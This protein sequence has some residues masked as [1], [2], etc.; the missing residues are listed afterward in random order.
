MTLALL[1]LLATNVCTAYGLWMSVRKAMALIEKIEEV[2]DFLEKC[3]L[4]IS[5]AHQ[6]FEEKSK[7]DVFSDEPIVKELV[8]EMKDT[9]EVFK[10]ALN[11]L[12][13]YSENVKE[14]PMDEKQE[15]T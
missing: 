12:Q 11:S 6:V 9:R 13:E 15:D 4:S 8:A 10:S 1:L 2:E 5:R 3:Y 14:G 7:I